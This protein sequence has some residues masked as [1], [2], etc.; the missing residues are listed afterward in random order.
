MITN[1]SVKDNEESTKDCE[2]K[3]LKIIVGTDLWPIKREMTE[4]DEY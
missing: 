3:G 1:I 2:E 4:Y